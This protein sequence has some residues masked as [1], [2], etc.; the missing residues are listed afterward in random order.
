VEYIYLQAN[1]AFETQTGLRVAD[2]LGKRAT[3][4]FAN[5]KEALFID[6]YGKVALTGEPVTF[7]R[8]FEPLQR[9]YHINAYQVG[10]DRFVTVFQ[11]ISERK[12]L[13]Q[14]V[15][16]ARVDFLFAVSH[17][18][19]TPLFLMASA[20]ELLEGLPAEHRAGRF[21]EYGEIWN[22]NLHRLRHLIDNLLDSQRTEGMGLKL[23]VVPTDLG[24]ILRQTL[25]DVDFLARRQRIRFRLQEDPLPMIPADPESIHRLFENLLTNAIKFSSPDGEVEI[26]LR[27]AEEEAVFTVRDFGFGIPASE[28][29]QLFQPFQRTD[30]ATQAV[31][32][33]TGLGLYTAKLITEAHGGSIALTS[34][35]GKGTKVTVRLPW[36]KEPE[37]G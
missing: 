30:G 17:E 25:K 13:E 3:E 26:E 14:E 18:L 7:E 35:L 9:H 31:I 36:V 29:P 12:R 37:Q 11:D 34:E 32:P 21:L 24:E 22:R 27:R 8:F 6:I 33:G 2:V 28:I 16:K 23:A 19:K 10:Q 1:A 20:Q 15:T 4:V 5:A